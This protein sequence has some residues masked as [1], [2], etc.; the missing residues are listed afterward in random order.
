MT[1]ETATETDVKAEAEAP[2]SMMKLTDSIEDMIY[3]AV[4]YMQ[5]VKYNIDIFMKLPEETAERKGKLFYDGFKEMADMLI[6]EGEN[7]DGMHIV[8]FESGKEVYYPIIEINAPYDKTDDIET[9]YGLSEKNCPTSISYNSKEKA[10]DKAKEFI[11]DKP[12]L[13][14]R[15]VHTE[16]SEMLYTLVRNSDNSPVWGAFTEYSYRAIA[17]QCFLEHK[18]A[19]LDYAASVGGID[20]E[21]LEKIKA[22][23]KKIRDKKKHSDAAP[24]KS[25]KKA[26]LPLPASVKPIPVEI[27]KQAETLKKHLL[28]YVENSRDTVY[29][30]G[31]EWLPDFEWLNALPDMVCLT[32]AWIKKEDVE[33]QE[34]DGADFYIPFTGVWRDTAEKL[35]YRFNAVLVCKACG[36]LSFKV[37]GVYTDLWELLRLNVPGAYYMLEHTVAD[38]DSCTDGCVDMSRVDLCMYTE[39]IR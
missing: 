11:K 28:E 15:G 17:V 39:N 35:D 23:D 20:K 13:E 37:T 27:R 33:I 12:E 6:H 16:Q 29:R 4:K 19:V 34:D 26:G 2:C 18:F 32:G 21:Y 5:G 30:P 31:N 14:Y 38:K 9:K 36:R 1:K 24:L 10:E 25:E 7:P 22:V 3:Y 8:S